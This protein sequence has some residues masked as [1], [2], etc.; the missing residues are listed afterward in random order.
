MRKKSP[1]TLRDRERNRAALAGARAKGAHTVWLTCENGDTWSSAIDP[2]SDDRAGA[3][4]PNCPK[5][6][7][8]YA[9]YRVLKAEFSESQQC[10][11]SCRKAL[12]PECVCIC[13]GVNHGVNGALA[14]S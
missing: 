3:V 2:R 9:T 7:K 10:G 6:N 13:A 4:T 5:C 12:E 11:P 1:T 8:F 14:R